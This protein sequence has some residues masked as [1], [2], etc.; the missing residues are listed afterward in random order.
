MA[1]MPQSQRLLIALVGSRRRSPQPSLQTPETRRIALVVWQG[2]RAAP[3]SLEFPAR[4]LRCLLSF[5][6]HFTPFLPAYR[7]RRAYMT[8]DVTCFIN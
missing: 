2:H 7:T 5:S 8:I 3:T 6:I 4:Q 1:K